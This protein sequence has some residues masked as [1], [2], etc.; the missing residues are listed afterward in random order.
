MKIPSVETIEDCFKQKGIWDKDYGL[1]IE[2]ARN[3]NRTC[4]MP[5]KGLQVCWWQDKGEVQ[6][7]DGGIIYAFE[8]TIF[9]QDMS[10]K[11]KSFASGLKDA[12]QR[13]PKYPF[14]Y[15]DEDKRTLWRCYNEKGKKI[16]CKEKNAVLSNSPYNVLLGLRRQRRTR[17][18]HR[19]P[20]IE[21][22]DA[23]MLVSKEIRIDS[24]QGVYDKYFA[25]L[26]KM[27]DTVQ[28]HFKLD[29]PE[30]MYSGRSGKKIYYKG[31]KKIG[32][33]K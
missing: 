6:G 28:T 33:K 17:P 2:N 9:T 18:L 23:A 27:D 21:R 26:M 19:L 1:C 13:H 20:E 10:S 4:T 15:W 25:E 8:P 5:F 16:G 24:G 30:Y 14:V 22:R 32:K 31:D 11:V 29:R 3:P 7:I 12:I